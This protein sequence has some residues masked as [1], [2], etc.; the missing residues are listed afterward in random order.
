MEGV[1]KVGETLTAMDLE[2]TNATVNYQWQRAD[3]EDSEYVDI[4]GATDST[5]TLDAEDEN[6]WIRVKVTG[7]G[8]YTGTVESEPVGPVEEVEEPV[9]T[10]AAD[11]DY[12]AVWNGDRGTWYIKVSVPEND[13]DAN[14]VKSITVIKEAGVEVT[15]PVALQPDTDKVMWFGVA[16]ADGEVTLK[17][18]GEYAYKVVRQD[19]SEY[20]FNF[21]Y[22]S[23]SVTGVT[24]VDT[25][26]E[27]VE[28]ALEA[29][30]EMTGVISGIVDRDIAALREHA[31]TLGLDLT[32]FDKI[33]AGDESSQEGG[34]QAAVI[35][36]LIANKPADGYDLDTLKD[37][38]AS[39]V[40]VRLANQNVM[41]SAN[42]D[43]ATIETL[44]GETPGT[45]L[46]VYNCPTGV[47]G[48][49]CFR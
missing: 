17:E 18:D 9:E 3:A 10:I 12:N 39:I 23:G 6:M 7:T 21:S 48:V 42:E 44:I 16:E 40:V 25:E 24:P 32:D 15:E 1:A 26:E 30:N 37:Y 34:R 45:V 19:D 33:F 11:V 4:D 28:A 49:P 29:I 27:A 38:F 46:A 2:P 20:I 22:A 13:L 35:R 31:P 36:D 41:D 5:Y 43:E 8:N 47:R 14:S